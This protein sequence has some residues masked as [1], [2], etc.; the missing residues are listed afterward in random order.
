MN[1]EQ[2]KRRHPQWAPAFY[3]NYR[4]PDVGYGMTCHPLARYFMSYHAS[5]A[6]AAMVRRLDLY[7]TVTLAL[8]AQWFIA[9]YPE[10]PIEYNQLSG[11][12]F[13]PFE[14]MVGKA[15]SERLHLGLGGA[16]KLGGGYEPYRYLVEARVEWQF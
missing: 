13:V 11:Q 16:V 3:L 10:N 2:Q 9:L 14:A 1:E 5:Y 4:V 12:W 15:V 7:P 8:P 6:G